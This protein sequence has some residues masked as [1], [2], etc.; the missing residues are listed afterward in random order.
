VDNK[1]CIIGVYFGKLPNY[2]SL[3]LKSCEYNPTIDFLLFTDNELNGLPKNVKSYITTLS[4]IKQKAST[5]LG[6][7]VCLERS[8]KLCDYKPLYGSIF[9]EYLTQ[10]DYW[11]H[12][13]FDL[14]FGDL[15]LFFDKYDLYEYDRFNALGHLSLY[16]NTDVVNERYMCD[17]S[18]VNYKNVF[19]TDKSCY[20]DELPCMTAI[21]SK[22][23]F[24][25]FTKYIFVDIAS[26]YDRYRIID[27]YPLDKKVVNYPYQIF[28]WERGKCYRAYLDKNGLHEEE[29]QYIHFKKRPDFT[30][31]FDIFSTDAFYITKMGFF[32]KESEATKSVIQSFNPYKGRIYEKFEKLINKFKI[33]FQLLKKKIR[34]V[35]SSFN[36][37][38]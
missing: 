2:F 11:G 7:D 26:L 3:W 19:T 31:E 1:I 30:V 32:K 22:H 24:P 36:G 15:Q 16:R 29:Y 5:C 20:F 4:N 38:N 37:S 25:I 14:I 13:D 34:A 35:V 9:K 28:Y 23:N 12:C 18:L 27:T 33:R 17:G 21:Y 6:F 8:Y 10:Y